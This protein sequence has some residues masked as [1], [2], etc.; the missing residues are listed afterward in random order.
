MMGRMMADGNM[1]VG[2]TQK[3]GKKLNNDVSDL[4]VYSDVVGQVLPDLST[5]VLPSDETSKYFFSL[6]NRAKSKRFELHFV[7]GHTLK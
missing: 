6:K 7:A 4:N 1:A 2:G 3:L 5:M